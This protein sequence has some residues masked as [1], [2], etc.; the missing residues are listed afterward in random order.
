MTGHGWYK[1]VI[2]AKDPAVNWYFDNW[3]GGTMGMSRHQKGCYIDLLGLQFQLGHLSIDQIKN[4]LGADFNQWNNLKVKF[5]EDEEGNFFNERLETEILKRKSYSE[6]GKKGGNPN[7]K[8]GAANPYYNNKDKLIDNLNDKQKDNLTGIGIETNT[9]IEDYGGVGEK[10]GRGPIIPLMQKVWLKSFPAYLDLTETDFP[11]LL[12][13]AELISKLEHLEF[14][15][16]NHELKEIILRRWGEIC[17][18][19]AN[20]NHY[21]TYSIERLAKHFQSLIQ[22]QKQHESN[23]KRTSKANGKLCGAERLIN[24]LKS[25]FARASAGRKSSD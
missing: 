1:N 2:M 23:K 8:K 7:F 22:A 18:F 19:C 16:E 4:I 15:P 12:K 14:D 6:R 11:A 10:E 24:E 17:T 5:S 13:I 25:D 3:F 21:S 9:G 20:D